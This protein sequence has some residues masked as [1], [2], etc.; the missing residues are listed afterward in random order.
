MGTVLGRAS[1]PRVGDGVSVLLG[2][3]DCLGPIWMCCLLSVNQDGS[4]VLMCRNGWKIL[5][6]ESDKRKPALPDL[7]MHSKLSK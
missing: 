6:K 1:H 5:E 7:I 3:R 2:S 4:H